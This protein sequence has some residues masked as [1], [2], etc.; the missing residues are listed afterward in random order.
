MYADDGIIFPESSADELKLTD[1]EAG[2]E[3]ALHKSS[4]L[5]REGVWEK[6]IKFLGLE[7]IPSGVS[8]KEG[9]EPKDYPR[10]RGFTRGLKDPSGRGS[11]L[12][13]G[14]R[15]QM[16]A[17]VDKSY[18][19]LR[20]KVFI[21]EDGQE[22]SIYEVVEEW[23]NPG[24][25]VS[26]WLEEKLKEFE[27]MEVSERIK[28]VF[29]EPAGPTLI[30]RMYN[31]KDTWEIEREKA[32]KLE[33]HKDSWCA[34]FWARYVYN[35]AFSG[36]V[37]EI[38]KNLVKYEG[39]VGEELKR[40]EESLEILGEFSVEDQREALWNLHIVNEDIL[41]SE[42]VSEESIQLLK[43]HREELE[44]ARESWRCLLELLELNISNSSSMAMDDLT[45]S[46]A[47]A[48]EWTDA[49]SEDEMEDPIIQ[50]YVHYNVRN[51]M[52]PR[53]KKSEEEIREEKKK[54]NRK[55]KKRSNREVR[56]WVRRDKGECQYLAAYRGLISTLEEKNLSDIFDYTVTLFRY[57]EALREADRLGIIDEVFGDEDE[58]SIISTVEPNNPSSS[59][60]PDDAVLS[61]LLT[62]Q[63]NPD[64]DIV[65]VEWDHLEEL[66]EIPT[67]DAGS[68]LHY[69]NVGPEFQQ[70]KEISQG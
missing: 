52:P 54:F 48:K 4:W 30:S 46:Y 66:V 3:Q 27:K 63:K 40:V 57:T 2:I 55:A 28:G 41:R 10:L 1:K 47:T 14:V 18:E 51:L 17:W 50:G 61:E 45:T 25:K 29:T 65:D 8:D 15:Q 68:E 53:K 9:G 26:D 34:K 24:K 43:N 62:A 56:D 49:W 22:R 6:S 19:D 35:L 60:D 32:V 70:E 37:F 5:K 69:D 36:R 11:R 64:Y 20:K 42:G 16:L 58:S 44:I 23:E 67:D 59:D 13:L 31:Y 12:E 38:M 33:A 39:L 21:K 7:W